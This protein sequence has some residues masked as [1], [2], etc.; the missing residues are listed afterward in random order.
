MPLHGSHVIEEKHRNYADRFVDALSTYR[1]F[2]DMINLG[3][4][5]TGSNPKVDF[6]I[7]IIGKD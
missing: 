4:Y 3:A 1:K 7:K 5:K 6:S 2:E